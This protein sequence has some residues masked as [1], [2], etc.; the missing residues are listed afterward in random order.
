M[1]DSDT[2]TPNAKP[3]SPEWD[4]AFGVSVSESL[5]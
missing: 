5:I 3:R 1:S 2:D 4:F